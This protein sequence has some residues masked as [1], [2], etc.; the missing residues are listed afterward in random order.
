VKLRGCVLWL[1]REEG[2]ATKYATYDVEGAKYGQTMPVHNLRWLLG[3]EEVARL[4]AGS[5]LFRDS[6]LV[7]LKQWPKASMMQLHLL[8]WRLQG[9]LPDPS[10]PYEPSAKDKKH[11]RSRVQR[12]MDKLRRLDS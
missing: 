12:E 5:G 6:E 4:Q 8:L 3:E 9:Y 10:L 11:R 7:V 1:P 2:A